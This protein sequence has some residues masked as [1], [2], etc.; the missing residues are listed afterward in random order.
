MRCPPLGLPADA[1]RETYEEGSFIFICLKTTEYTTEK[2]CGP[3]EVYD[4][5]G[6]GE[7]S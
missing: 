4:A 3:K 1:A 6:R 5:N 2:I 7:R